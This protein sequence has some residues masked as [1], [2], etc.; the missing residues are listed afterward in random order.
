MRSHE[1]PLYSGSQGSLE[2]SKGGVVR[3]LQYLFKSILSGGGG[4]AGS[5]GPVV[6]GAVGAAGPLEPIIVMAIPV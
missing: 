5:V 6:G 1:R 2:G 4:G 3:V